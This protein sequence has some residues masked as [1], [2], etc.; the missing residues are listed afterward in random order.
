MKIEYKRITFKKVFQKLKEGEYHNA[1]VAYNKRE[2]LGQTRVLSE[3]EAKEK[4]YAVENVCIQHKHYLVMDLWFLTLEFA[5]LS[6]NTLGDRDA[7][8]RLL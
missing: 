4:G 6:P 5:W 1:V 7:V 8:H 3:E 2:W